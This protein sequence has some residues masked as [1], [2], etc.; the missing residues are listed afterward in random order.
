MESSLA[1]QCRVLHFDDG[2]YSLNTILSLFHIIIFLC[3]AGSVGVVPL[4]WL[5]LQVF[6]CPHR[7]RIHPCPFDVISRIE[8]NTAN[9]L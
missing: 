6:L 3:C 7:L 9:Q 1:L 8:S 4:V 2:N 5:P